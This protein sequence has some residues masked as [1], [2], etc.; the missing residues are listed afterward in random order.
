MFLWVAK[1][2]RLVPDKVTF[3]HGDVQSLDVVPGASVPQAILQSMLFME[4]WP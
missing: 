4:T 3:W 2:K 1:G